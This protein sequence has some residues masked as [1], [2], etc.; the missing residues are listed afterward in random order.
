MGPRAGICPVGSE[1]IAH[2]SVRSVFEASSL[3]SSGPDQ[4]GLGLVRPECTRSHGRSC[5]RDCDRD[6]RNSNHT[7][8]IG[9]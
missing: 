7:I 8:L 3:P 1:T 2:D 6:R 5:D 9:H 4:V